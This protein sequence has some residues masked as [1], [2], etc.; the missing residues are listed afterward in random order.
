MK[1]NTD[2]PKRINN[3]FIVT[4]VFSF[5]N[6]EEFQIVAAVF[7]KYKHDMTLTIDEKTLEIKCD[8]WLPIPPF[9]QAIESLE[10]LNVIILEAYNEDLKKK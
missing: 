5:E 9:I 7:C 6:H 3:N 1:V 2:E 8:T 10:K 4:Y